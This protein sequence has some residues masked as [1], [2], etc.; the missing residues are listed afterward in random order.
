MYC[1][2]CG[3]KIRDDSRFCLYCGTKVEEDVRG[4]MAYVHT[5]AAGNGERGR[6]GKKYKNGIIISVAAVFVAAFAVF[7]GIHIY[8]KPENRLSRALDLGQKYLLEEDYEQAVVAFD[9]VIE[10]EPMNVD[11]Y[12]GKAEAYIGMDHYDMAIEALEEG[13]QI[14]KKDEKIEDNLIG[15]YIE[16]VDDRIIM[17]G[18]EERLEI[19]DRLLE[20]AGENEEVLRGLEAC[21]NQYIAVLMDEEK[22]DEIQI[23]INEYKNIAEDI[24]FDA[25]STQTEMRIKEMEYAPL[26]RAMQELIIAENYEQANVLVQT[27]EYRD[28]IA[29]LHGKESYYCGEYNEQGEREGSGTA[30]YLGG[31]GGYFYCG[32]FSGG[33]RNGTGKAVFLMPDSAKMPYG[34]YVGNWINDLPNGEGE[35]R[36]E[37]VQSE[38]EEDAGTDSRIRGTYLDGLYNGDM[39]IEVTWSYGVDRWHGMAEN[40]AWVRQGEIREGKAPV[41]IQ[42]ETGKTDMWIEMEENEGWG[43]LWRLMPP[44]E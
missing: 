33:K 11:A 3:K 29:S 2:N 13:Y 42:A 12:V 30:V 39:Y 27:R 28:M 20:L 41:W 37:V 15:I 36:Y 18:Y 21:L 1:E 19:Y 5:D 23:L 16:V 25:I 32:S 34:F 7:T 43:V 24:D 6:K 40:G 10:I 44:G 4:G 14:T 9:K 38:L 26:L 31:D 22:Y 8:N 17:D 35:E